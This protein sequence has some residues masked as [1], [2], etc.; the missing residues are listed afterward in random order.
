MEFWINVGLTVTNFSKIRGDLNWTGAHLPRKCLFTPWLRCSR[1]RYVWEKCLKQRLV[2]RA[3]QTFSINYNISTWASS[4]QSSHGKYCVILLSKSI[5]QEK[6]TMAWYSRDYSY[7]FFYFIDWR[8]YS[9]FQPLTD[10]TTM[11]SVN[12]GWISFTVWGGVFAY[13]K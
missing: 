10:A 13:N 1:C 3:F 6:V 7:A 4:A 12:N 9:S 2:R 8:E 11:V 5:A